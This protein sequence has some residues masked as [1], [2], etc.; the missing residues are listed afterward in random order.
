MSPA[1]GPP[2]CGPAAGDAWPKRQLVSQL[3][4]FPTVRIDDASG[5]WRASPV[6][7]IVARRPSVW[8]LQVPVLGKAL[9][10]VRSENKMEK[11]FL[12]GV[13]WR[14]VAMTSTLLL[15]LACTGRI[16]AEGSTPGQTGGPAGIAGT[17]S[18][19]G[20]GTNGTGTAGSGSAG[21][22][23]PPSTDPGVVVVDP[24]AFTPAPGM[25]RRLTRTQFRN[26]IKDILRY[27]VRHQTISTPIAGTPTSRASAPRSS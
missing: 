13:V 3:S 9:T 8:R 26:A 4:R 14:D 10:L 15:G 22:G 20:G 1:G 7:L 27:A 23:A 24:P 6:D 19:G 2:V 25:L 18:P 17:G 5:W 16:G 11:P 12:R 21:S